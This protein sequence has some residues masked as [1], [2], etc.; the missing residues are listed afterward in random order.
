M[1]SPRR[2]SPADKI[3]LRPSSRRE[4][5]RAP[6]AA[7]ATRIVGARHLHHHATIAGIRPAVKLD[8][9]R[10]MKQRDTP[11]DQPRRARARPPEH[12]G[13]LPPCWGIAPGRKEHKSTA[14]KQSRT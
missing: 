4:S 5:I 2:G 6:G 3:A 9:H 12:P 11:P 1:R 8:L 13:L 7:G 14:K 10:D